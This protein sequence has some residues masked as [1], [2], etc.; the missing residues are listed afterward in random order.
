MSALDLACGA[1][2]GFCGAPCANAGEAVPPASVTAR[3]AASIVR[4]SGGRAN[5]VA[6]EAFGATRSEVIAV[7]TLQI[8]PPGD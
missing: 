6:P 3:N 8:C 1:G 2:G 5:S 7:L 4:A